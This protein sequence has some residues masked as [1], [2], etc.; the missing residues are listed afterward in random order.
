MC[1]FRVLASTCLTCW[2]NAI[3]CAC[4]LL[5]APL[6]VDTASPQRCTSLFALQKIDCNYIVCTLR[7]RILRCFVQFQE[8]KSPQVRC[9]KFV[10]AMAR[11]TMRHHIFI[12]PA[13]MSLC[14]LGT[15]VY[16]TRG[17]RSDLRKFRLSRRITTYIDPEIEA[18]NRPAMRS[19]KMNVSYRYLELVAPLHIIG[20]C[21]MLAGIVVGSFVHKTVGSHC[22]AAVCYRNII[23]QNMAIANKRGGCHESKGPFEL[24]KLSGGF[25]HV[26]LIF[27]TAG[28]ANFW[29]ASGPK[30]AICRS[31]N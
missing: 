8:K 12:S 29:R 18:E 20:L 6:L 5:S 28:G 19:Q 14:R 24:G 4:C 13:V 7:L 25:G 23:C 27:W 9:A 21:P 26:L 10:R 15:I 22:F 16:R 2:L 11:K 17:C 3:R 30:N 31:Q 1:C